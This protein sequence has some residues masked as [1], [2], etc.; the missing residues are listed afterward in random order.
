MCPK[1]ENFCNTS[2]REIHLASTADRNSGTQEMKTCP[3]S[4]LVPILVFEYL[5]PSNRKL[6]DDTFGYQIID[7]SVIKSCATERFCTNLL[8]EG[9]TKSQEVIQVAQEPALV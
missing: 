9:L 3:P 7:L 2:Q 6:F 1:S 4:S 5:Q 8:V